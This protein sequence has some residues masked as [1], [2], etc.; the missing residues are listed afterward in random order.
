MSAASDSGVHCDAISA[1]QMCVDVQTMRG[2]ICRGR[3]SGCFHG[4]EHRRRSSGCRRSNDHHAVQV[5]PQVPFAR[6]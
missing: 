4:C 1:N 5:R 2:S 6:S 3:R